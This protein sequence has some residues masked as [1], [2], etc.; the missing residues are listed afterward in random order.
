MS[1]QLSVAIEF[2]PFGRGWNKS[3][4]GKEISCVV[5]AEVTLRITVVVIKQ[6][7]HCL[8]D[9]N[10]VPNAYY[11][12]TNDDMINV[13]HILCLHVNDKQTEVFNGFDIII[14]RFDCYWD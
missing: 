2:S 13:S 8:I 11:V 9:S 10:G 6:L 14:S 5:V 7:S 12:V 1:S 4:L 3:S